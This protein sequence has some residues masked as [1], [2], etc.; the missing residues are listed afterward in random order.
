MIFFPFIR[1][2]PNLYLIFFIQSYWIQS[3][4]KKIYFTNKYD[5]KVI[6]N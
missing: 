3:I 6:N 5:P 2:F 1:L 4:S